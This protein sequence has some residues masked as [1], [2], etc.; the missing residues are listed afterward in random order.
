MGFFKVLFGGKEDSAEEREEKKRENDFDVLKVD[1]IQAMRI[2]RYP[3]AV[4]CLRKA[5]EI[6]EEQEAHEYL[7]SAL[8]RND[9]REGAAEELEKL[10]Q[11]YPEE[12]KYAVNRANVLYEIEEYEMAEQECNKA[13]KHYPNL[14]IPYYVLAQISMAREEYQQAENFASKAVE[15]NN[16]FLDALQL[17]A[18]TKIKNG[19]LGEAEKDIDILIKREYNLDES[20]LLKAKVMEEMDRPNDAITYYN[21]VLEQNPFMR[22]AYADLASLYVKMKEMDKAKKTIE[23]CIEQNGESAEIIN[24]RAALKDAMGDKKG[25]Q[26]DLEKVIRLTQ[27][28]E[29]IEDV[30]IERQVNQQ[31][32]S[33]NPFQ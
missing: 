21:N 5:V 17:C 30:D 20:L 15:N 13:I 33:I 24:A 9:D 6:K 29:D 10:E 25:A 31:Y 19:K 14:A 28:D 11:L 4:A 2:G 3:Y 23:E 26:E 18:E 12:I 16:D 22:K 32:N 7:V 1:G 27:E 8:V